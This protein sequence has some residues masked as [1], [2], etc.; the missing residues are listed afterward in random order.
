[1]ADF[2]FDTLKVD[3]DRG[4]VG[5]R[6]VRQG[7][8]RQLREAFQSKGGTV[9][10]RQDFDTK[11]TTTSSRSSSVPRTP[12]A[13]GIYA[14]ATSATK[15]CIPRAQSKGILDVPYIGPDG[16]GDDPVHQGRR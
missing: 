15:G 9:V 6:D 8:R 1:M 13:Q 5:Q 11:T 14:G 16:I 7:R 10:V 4:V 3:E 2:A 12:G